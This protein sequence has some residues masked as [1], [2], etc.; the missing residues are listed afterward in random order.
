MKAHAVVFFLAGWAVPGLGHLLQKKFFRGI[1]FLVCLGGMTA[2][3]LA[4]G[5][6]IFSFQLENPLTVLA[7]FA[8]IGNGLVYVLSRIL[9]FGLGALKNV[10]YEFGTAYLAGAG[11]LNF[12]IALDAFDIAAGKKK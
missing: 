4:M 2:L 1:A 9:P 8:D 11:L 3:G 12:L 6:R 7:F 10:T 5:G